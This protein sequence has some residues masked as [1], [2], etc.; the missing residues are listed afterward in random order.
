MRPAG[1]TGDA[2]ALDVFSGGGEMGRLMAEADW[3]RTAL[4]PPAHWPLGLKLALRILLTSRYAMWLGWGPELTFFYNDAYRPTLGVKH[5]WALGRPAREVWAEVWDTIRTR[6]PLVLKEGR[7]T[8]DEGLLLFLER[9]GFPEETYHTFSYSPLP[10]DDGSIGGMLCVVTEET[11]RIIGERRLKVLHDLGEALAAAKSEGDIGPGLERCLAD[12]PHDLPFALAYLFEADGGPARRLACIGLSD[13]HP[14]APPLLAGQDDDPWPLAAIQAGLPVTVADL[15]ERF[16]SLPAGVW[17]VPPR[18]AVLVPIA[19]HGQLR[20]AG[21][22][23]AGINPFR[24]LDSDYTG[25]LD[26]LAGQVSLALGNARAWEA[27]RRRAEGLAALDRAKTAFFSNISH[28]FRTPLTLLLGPLEEMLAGTAPDDPRR[29]ELETVQ[30]NALRLLRLV[31][32]LLDFSRIEAGRFQARFHPVDLAVVTRDLAGVFRAVMERAG[33]A[34]HVRCQ[35]LPEPAYVDPDMWEKIV[36]NLLSNAFKFTFV[37]R[38]EVT[39]AAAGREAVLTVSD[40]GTGIPAHEVPRLFERFHRVEGAEGRSHEGSGIGLAMVHELVQ[41]HGGSVGAVS[42]LGKGSTFTVTLPL[43]RA[44]LP[45]DQ[46]VEAPPPAGAAAAASFVDEVRLWLPEAPAGPA[47]AAGTAAER[48]RIVLADD[49]ADMRDYVARLLEGSYRVEAVDNGHAALEAVRRE[50]CDLVLSD[51]MM[52][53]MDGFDLLRALRADPALRDIPMV[54]LSARA[55]EEARIEGLD[56]GAD[57]Y[58]VKPFSAR[59][60]LARIR[61]NLQM[62]RLRRE[63]AWA[64]R[65]SEER[66]R[67][68]QE[69]ARIGHWDWDLARDRIWASSSQFRLLGWD[70]EAGEEDSATFFEPVHPE[71]R[72][73]L[74][75]EIEAAKAGRGFVN[76]E[77]RVIMPGG[78]VRWLA[79][80]A[81][82]VRDEEGEPQRVIGVNF[83]V[84]ERREGE[85][86]RRLL[87]A[88]VDH[89]AKNMLAVVQ[90]MLR[91]TKADSTEGFVAAVDGRIAAL[92]RTHT[93]LAQGRW[94]GATLRSLVEEE[95]AAFRA[96]GRQSVQIDGPP[97]A[98]GPTAVQA[99]GLALHELATNAVKYGALSVPGGT[100]RISWERTANGGL[101]FSWR[102]IGGPAV[103]RPQRT[104]FGTTVIEQSLRHQLGGA[105]RS[106]WL[107]EGL[108]IE[109]RIGPEH[110]V[111]D[112]RNP[113][114]ETVAAPPPPAAALAGRRILVVEDEGLIA[115]E[116][117]GIVAGA[118]GTAVGPAATL[119]EATRLAAIEALDG[120]VLDIRL[121]NRRVFAVADLLEDRGIPYLFCSGYGR[122]ADLEGRFTDAP[123]LRKP[124]TRDQLLGELAGLLRP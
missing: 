107:P 8:W 81:E 71:D 94:S 14:A 39:L 103:A 38:V 18:Q 1:A 83:D 84:T 114:A 59:E 95:M 66:L 88:E 109:A 25:F 85:E 75:A 115:Q 53:Q 79:A 42:T 123:I 122:E 30:R 10:D 13:D 82:L 40:T 48:P 91:L 19:Q 22:L 5:P 78:L 37:G 46:V 118:G 47:T 44:H 69:A 31:N 111:E 117:A 80:R 92:A 89:R 90:A 101:R 11:H 24:Q 120:A 6:A 77:F 72:A 54:L 112:T 21:F 65:K 52:P 34:L 56:A 36:L 4:G 55:G 108:A 119:A 93:L 106:D 20:P 2:L 116:V 124:F 76:T 63:S 67:L 7:A 43:G 23:I 110:V 50:R 12:A 27:E 73:A 99:F 35:P 113:P 64:L 104:G 58:L 86:R 15:A 105:V 33:L 9:S 60:L 16:P 57:D 49:N 41:L 98:L 17:P 29:P 26:L 3:S 74:M 62:A 102:E 121:G 28:E 100:V 51:V 96:A 32:T 45:A 97:L 61:T 68:A 87:M 70:A